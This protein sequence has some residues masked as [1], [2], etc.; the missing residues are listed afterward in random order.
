VAG[1]EGVE[2]PRVDR[3]GSPGTAIR[4]TRHRSRICGPTPV[5]H[6]AL[7][8]EGRHH[9]DDAETGQKRSDDR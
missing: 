6:C 3:S 4:P 8:G 9:L 7:P 2:R 1:C 5:P